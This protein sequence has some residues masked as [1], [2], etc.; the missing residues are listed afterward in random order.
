MK[1]KL[2]INWKPTDADTSHSGL[3]QKDGRSYASNG[4]GMHRR[5]YAA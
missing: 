1:G 4:W 5:D 2:Q 3:R